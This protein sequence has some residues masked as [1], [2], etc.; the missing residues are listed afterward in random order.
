M[1]TNFVGC[2]RDVLFNAVHSILEAQRNVS[3]YVIEGNVTFNC[4][5]STYEPITFTNDKAVLRIPTA[6]AQHKVREMFSSI[7]MCRY[8]V[9]R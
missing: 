7:C 9:L 1:V 2:L 6:H 3:G 4:P 8:F 5:P